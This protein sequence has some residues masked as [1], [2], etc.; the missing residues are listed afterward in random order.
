LHDINP[1]KVYHTEVLWLPRFLHDDV[2]GISVLDLARSLRLGD[3]E[4]LGVTQAFP[5][6][7][8]HHPAASRAG[9][10]P[11]GDQLVQVEPGLWISLDTRYLVVNNA[12]NADNHFFISPGCAPIWLQEPTLRRVS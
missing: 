9:D 7:L 5:H 4:F 2:P 8:Y 10:F 12:R 6:V 3:Y 1:L 11:T